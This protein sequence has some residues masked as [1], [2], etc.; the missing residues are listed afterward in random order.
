MAL[1]LLPGLLRLAHTSLELVQFMSKHD[2]DSA[3]RKNFNDIWSVDAYILVFLGHVAHKCLHQLEDS[4][5]STASTIF[6]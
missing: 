1:D 3:V 6:N 4:I 5:C 2:I